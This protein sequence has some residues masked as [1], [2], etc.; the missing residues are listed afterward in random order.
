MNYLPNV[1]LYRHN[2]FG[3][4]FAVLKSQIMFYDLTIVFSGKLTYIIDEQVIDVVA[5]DAIFIKSGSTRERLLSPTPVDYVSFNFVMNDDLSR[6]NVH[7]NKLNGLKKEGKS[8]QYEKD[9][10]D[11]PT[12]IPGVIENEIKLLIASIDVIDQNNNMVFLDNTISALIL[13]NILYI[14]KS[15]LNAP[16]ISPT[17]EQIEKYLIDNYSKKITLDDIAKLTYFSKTHCH[18]LFNREKGCSIMTYLNKIRIDKAKELL[19][20]GVLSLTD[21]SDSLGFE[22][23]NYFSRLFSKKT[24]I[25]LKN[26]VA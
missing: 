1:I 14:L 8:D 2:K 18:V 4:R 5:G 24:G 23:Y 9:F 11:L 13:S 6:D 19:I 10:L 15:K 12:H 20:E 16:T 17:V 7:L 3:K 26:F 25:H 21:I 22:S